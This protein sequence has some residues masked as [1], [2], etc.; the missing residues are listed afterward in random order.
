LTV[1]WEAAHNAVRS[2]GDL[3]GKVLVDATNPVAMSLRAFGKCF[4]L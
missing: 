3:T 1:P 4:G 2:A